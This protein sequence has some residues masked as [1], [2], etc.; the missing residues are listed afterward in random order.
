MIERWFPCA[1]VNSASA[2]GWGLGRAEKAVFPWFAARPPAQAKAAVLC[3]LLPWPEDEAEQTRLQELVRRAMSGRYEGWRELR[4][5]ILAANPDGASV[6]DPFSG[7]GMIPLEAAR[8]GL[9]ATGVEYSPV[10]TIASQLLAD[11]PY[12]DWSQEPKLPWGGD[13]STVIDGGQ[14]KF[15]N[16]VEA[17]LTTIGDRWEGSVSEFYPKHQGKAPWAYLWA[18][19]VPC[20]DCGHRFPLVGSYELRPE[21]TR[22][23][24]RGGPAVVDAGQSFYVEG[25]R[26]SGSWNVVVHDGIPAKTPTLANALDANGKKIVGKS[27][28]CPHCGHVHPLE[29][30]KRLAAEGHGEDALLVVA[31]IDTDTGKKYRVPEVAEIEAARAAARAL[32]EEKNFAPLTPAVPDEQIP[33]NNGSTIRPQL[34]GS[35]TY[36][37]LMCDRQTLSFVRLA[38]VVNEV[39]QEL[40]DLGCGDE[41]VRALSGYVGSVICRKLKYSTRGAT[42]YVGN[43]QLDHIFVNEST[44]KHSYDF[45]EAGI[46]DGPGT[47]NSLVRSALTTLWSVFEEMRPVGVPATVLRGSAVALPMRAGAVAAV[48][49]DPPYDAMVYYSDASDFF[50]VWLKRALWRSHPE[51]LVTPDPRG[52]QDKTQEI[53]VKNHGRAP[54]EHRDQDHYDTMLARAFVEMRRAVQDDGVVSIVFGSGD[55]EVWSRLLA[56]IGNAG[57]VMTASWPA[58]TEAGGQQNKANIKTTVTMACRPAPA[59]R[60]AGR[61]GVVESEIYAEIT[62]RYANWERDGLAPADMLMAASGPAMEVV[63]RYREV[64]DAKGEPVG[65]ETFLPL[66]RSAVQSAMSVIVEH[67]PLETFDSRTRFA[68]WWVQIYGRQVQA[69]SA[70]RWEGMA[71]SL[72]MD[73][74]RDLVPDTGQGVSLITSSKFKHTLGKDSSVID[75][76][77]MLAKVSEDGMDAM[78]EVMA[79]SGRTTEDVYLWAAIKFLADQL[80]SSDPDAISFSRILRGKDHIGTAT[81]AAKSRANLAKLKR[82]DDE[83]QGT[84]L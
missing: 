17:V 45:L 8:M 83:N 19:T 27:A 15:I 5:E 39:C 65:I 76:A 13:G 53:I 80:P 7:R 52:L 62:G 74:V 75:V 69:K 33:L 30:H 10:A 29:V 11:Y 61:K 2:G 72:N 55:P 59:G 25:D 71:S 36:G 73:D 16:D 66:A 77:L 12:R 54:G 42:L 79:K 63:G 6:L 47:W 46:S 64:L 70:L 18:V 24:K 23:P 31:D 41:Y 51:L 37:D 3:S 34:Y 60:P 40:R 78:A 28:I 35:S 26:R 57:L 44:I 1:E 21:K 9:P 56:V 50:Y 68:L 48:V 67:H 43:Q 14:S 49:T 84:L 4:K 82:S 32:R 22:H 38:R 20:Q 81:E 58:N